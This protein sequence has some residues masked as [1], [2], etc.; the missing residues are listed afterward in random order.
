ML[1]SFDFWSFIRLVS[2]LCIQLTG[3]RRFNRVRFV[4]SGGARASERSKHSEISRDSDRLQ[5]RVQKLVTAR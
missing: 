3:S 1:E 4:G 2:A 5:I